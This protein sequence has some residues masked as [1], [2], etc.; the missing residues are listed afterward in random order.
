MHAFRF[1]FVLIIFSI[2][3]V[4]A[5]T[6]K[7]KQ[8]YDLTSALLPYKVVKQYDHP[9]TI[10]TQGLIL[11]NDLMFESSGGY[12]VSKLYIHNIESGKLKYQA[13][14]PA[15]YFAEGITILNEKLFMLTWKSGIAFQFNIN[16]LMAPNTSQDVLAPKQHRYKGFGWG[17]TDNRQQLI[18]S[19]GR[20]SVNC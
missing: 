3:A 8:P 7:F 1:L 6:I 18:M 10:F 15:M 2:S 11:H 16:D 9:S 19:D 20:G 4:C 13:A 14:V 5:E 12:G 17:L